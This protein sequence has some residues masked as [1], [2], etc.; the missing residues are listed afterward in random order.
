MAKFTNLD[1]PVR[2]NR[3][4]Q[5][6]KY[7]VVLLV[8]L[9]AGLVLVPIQLS[10]AQ[11]PC[12]QVSNTRV[13]KAA[14]QRF[15]KGW[16]IWTADTRQI[17][18]LIDS[19]PASTGLAGAVEIYTETWQEGETNNDPSLVP[20]PGQIQPSRGF[21]KVW[22]ETSGLRDRIGFAWNEPVA[23][24]GMVHTV[25]SNIWIN[26]NAGH[27]YAL[28]GSTWAIGDQWGFMSGKP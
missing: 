18:V 20:P 10:S 11:T 22:R 15:Q 8:G 19:D 7:A 23:F 14:L 6:A 12:P 9:V 21:G 3:R 2:T 4:N 16:M 25:G 27:I 1:A 24:T 28:T 26:S 5:L 13:T 17:Y